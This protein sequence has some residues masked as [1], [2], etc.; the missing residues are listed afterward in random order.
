[1]KKRLKIAMI[2][3]L[4]VLTLSASF[5]IYGSMQTTNIANGNPENRPPYNHPVVILPQE[6][7]L[8]L[9]K[10]EI[11]AFL[12]H[13]TAVAINGSVVALVKGMLIV[14]TADVHVTIL[15]PGNWTVDN[16]VINREI[17]FN[18]TFSGVGQNITVKALKGVLFTHDN[19]SINIMMGYEI[20]NSKGIPA[21]ALLPF[22]IETKP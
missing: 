4:L 12:N 19:F 7:L 20:I 11:K 8:G 6:K 18:G 9:T 17:L 15:I 13:A 16:M 22:N 10:G 21:F 14:N 1:M 3:A 5:L 2:L